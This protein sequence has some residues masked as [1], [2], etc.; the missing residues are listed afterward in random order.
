MSKT[1]W[2]FNINI[3]TIKNGYRKLVPVN[4]WRDVS[5]V[6][7]EEFTGMLEYASEV[8]GIKGEL[9]ILRDELKHAKAEIETLKSTIRNELKN[10]SGHI[11]YE[12]DLMNKLLG[13][14]NNGTN[15]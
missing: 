3:F 8:A 2:L 1:H 9:D 11:N 7:T 5:Y 15:A 10:I 12:V 6:D 4:E 14:E 13:D